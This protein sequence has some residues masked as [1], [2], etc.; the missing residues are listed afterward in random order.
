MTDTPTRQ[1]DSTDEEADRQ[2]EDGGTDA[3]RP[4]TDGG[5]DRRTTD[6]PTVVVPVQVMEGQSVP[7]GLA[8]FLAPVSVV[9]LG[10][11]VLPEQTP[12]EQASLQFEDR[13]RAAVDDIAAV[14][15]DEGDGV[16]TRVTFTHD[17]DDTIERVADEVDA[18]AV[19]LS[20]PVGEVDELLVALRTAGETER[21][22]DLVGTLAGDARVRLWGLASDGFDAETAVATARDRLVDRG[23]AAERVETETSATET[24]VAAVVDRSEGADVI[25]I[26]EGGTT[27]FSQIFGDEGERVAD[28]A[29]APVVVVRDPHTDETES[30]EY[31]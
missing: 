17:R 21:V 20:N 28:G 14:F 3:G 10:Y 29:L 12:T 16:E 30:P 31:T 2:T 7:P 19:V 15:S 1:T 25:A 24:P 6:Q 23:V 11:H 5:M 26:G 18:A 9:V 22:V 4:A 27:L 13:A 8:A